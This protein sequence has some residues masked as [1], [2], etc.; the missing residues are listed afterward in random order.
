MRVE[1]SGSGIA[2]R[3]DSKE[4]ECQTISAS[5]MLDCL[6]ASLSS[7]RVMLHFFCA[8]ILFCDSFL[9]IH[10][11]H[12]VASSFAL[13][14]PP[15]ARIPSSSLPASKVM[16]KITIFSARRY[17]SSARDYHDP[18]LAPCNAIKMQ[19]L[20]ISFVM[21]LKFGTFDENSERGR[22]ES[23]ESSSKTECT[24]APNV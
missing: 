10:A 2:G 3:D 13:F 21:V 23:D 1:K 12:F 14:A 5:V 9:V 11:F 17:C 16:A 24:R 7:E 20:H 8:P 22:K 6:V 19:S 15:R 18:F 4:K